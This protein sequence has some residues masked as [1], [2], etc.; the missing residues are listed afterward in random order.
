M[1]T[2]TITREEF[3]KRLDAVNEQRARE[4]QAME[5]QQAAV[6]QLLARYERSLDEIEARLEKTEEPV[7]PPAFLRRRLNELAEKTAALATS[8]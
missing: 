4:L 1:A 6:E 8:L 5:E 2:E 3:D 7:S